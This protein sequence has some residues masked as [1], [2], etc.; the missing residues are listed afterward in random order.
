MKTIVW[1]AAFVIVLLVLCAPG[2]ALT[3]VPT[4]TSNVISLPN[5]SQ[6]ESAF[7]YA[8]THY[9]NLFSN[10]IT[11]NITLDAVPGTSVFSDS[12]TNLYG[13]F[14]YTQVHNALLADKTSA[15]QQSVISSLNS[16]DP[17]GSNNYWLPVAQSLALGLDPNGPT[18]TT[19]SGT[20]TFGEGNNFTFD[21]NNRAVA[22]EFDFIGAAEHEIAE[23]LG[24]SAGLGTTS[25][26]GSPAYLV[27]DLFRYT[28]PGVR[29][30]NRT[31]SGVYFSINGGSTNLKQYN[32]PGNGGDLGD[33][34]IG[35][36]PDSYNAFQSSG[37]ENLLTPVDLTQMEVLGYNLASSSTATWSST[38]STGYGTAP[39]WNLPEVPNAAGQIATFGTGSQANITLSGAS[40]T[41]GQLVFSSSSTAYNLGTDRSGSI[42]LSNLGTGAVV[43]VGGGSSAAAT[44]TIGTTLILVDASKSTTFSIASNNSLVVSGSINESSVTGQQIMLSG[45]GTLELDGTNGYTGGTIVTNSGTLNVGSNGPGTLGSGSLNISGSSSIVNIGADVASH[46]LSIGSLS[47]IG[48]GPNECGQ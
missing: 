6:V 14:S 42:T 7:N 29:S 13:S 8:C 28:A 40:F 23:V 31:D 12:N 10:P 37:V 20:V 15:N 1:A 43:T 19:S 33:W 38:S 35:Q 36:G 32:V 45:G 27:D 22:G 18:D 11:L 21:P 26:N 25:F 17:T 47:G 30:L 3:I 46:G 48:R 41:V 44:P 4:Y 9:D 5:A 39:N 34:A 24:R 16:T 2:D